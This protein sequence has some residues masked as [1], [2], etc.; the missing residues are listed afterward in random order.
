MKSFSIGGNA[1]IIVFFNLVYTIHG[2]FVQTPDDRSHDLIKMSNPAK[3]RARET[4][5]PFS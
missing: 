4:P 3:I 5:P 1:L 2:T